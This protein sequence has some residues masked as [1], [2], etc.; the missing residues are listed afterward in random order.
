MLTIGLTGKTGAGKSTV[1]L[2]L[3]EKGC[4]IIDGDVIART[5]TEKGSEVLSEL[6]AAFGD[7]ILDSD[8]RLIR[9]TLAARAFSSGENTALLNRITHPHIK[10]KCEA[11]ISLAENEGYTVSV[12]D[13]A[14]LLE[15]DIKNLCRKIV[16]VTAPEEIR[17]KRILERDNI[18]NEQAMTRI[19]AQ[20]DDEYYFERA[21]I[22]IKNY[23]PFDKDNSLYKEL[24]ELIN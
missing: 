3:K 13:A 11:E 4:R 9:P 8:G 18:T 17:L 16:V 14:A 15:S 23:P 7:D 5:I 19:K 1:A 24:E 6:Q 20:K 12:I 10:R 22:I 2:Y 21:D